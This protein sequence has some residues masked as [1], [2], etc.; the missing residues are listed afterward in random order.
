MV[1]RQDSS[2]LR[3]E[4]FPISTSA[5]VHSRFSSY[6]RIYLGL[7][8]M[9]KSE[10]KY[11]EHVKNLGARVQN[12]YPKFRAIL[13]MDEYVILELYIWFDMMWRKITSSSVASLLRGPNLR[14][15]NWTHRIILDHYRLAQ[16]CS[17]VG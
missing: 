7:M 13:A 1:R 14:A 4:E 3:G 6:R 12:A 8:R 17:Q 5:E 2:S 11:S 16:T 15:E 10:K 9:Y